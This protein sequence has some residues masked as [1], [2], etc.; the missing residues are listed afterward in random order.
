MRISA[1]L[2]AALVLT[3]AMLAGGAAPAAAEAPL[4]TV[5]L[6]AGA[7]HH[8]NTAKVTYERVPGAANSVRITYVLITAGERDCAWVQWNDPN[9][10]S[11]DGW[12]SLTPEPSCYGIGMGEPRDLVISAPPGH[13]LKVRLAADHGNSQWVHKDIAK[14]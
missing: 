13:P 14:L 5:D 6:E 7:N 11:W 2:P 12:T 4:L 9:S 3:A 1:A 8:R 10:S